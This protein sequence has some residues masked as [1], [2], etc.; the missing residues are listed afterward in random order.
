VYDNVRQSIASLHEPP[1]AARTDWLQSAQQLADELESAGGTVATV[2]WEIADGWFSRKE[3]VELLAIMREAL[4]NIRKHGGASRAYI[5]A[6]ITREYGRYAEFRCVVEDDGAGYR[7]EEL[8][9]KGKYGVKMMRERAASMGWT[10]RYGH[11][12]P[13]GT[14]IDI[15]GRCSLHEW[16]ADQRAPCRRP[17]A[18][19]GRNAGYSGGGPFLPGCG[20]S[21]QRRRSDR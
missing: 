21:G 20:G 17:S 6:D 14:I 12:E 1:T 2:E 4:M 5:R 18:R 16:K 10:L 7:E 8:V 3:K 9:A 13:S 15:E 11:R 19:A